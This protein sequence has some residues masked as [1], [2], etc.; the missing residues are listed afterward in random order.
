MRLVI[1]GGSFRSLGDQVKSLGVVYEM[2]PSLGV[3]LRP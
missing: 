2:N 3:S 1:A